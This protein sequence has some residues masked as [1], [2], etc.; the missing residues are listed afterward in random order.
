MPKVS[1]LQGNF[2]TG[3][4]SPL[5]YG[6]VDVDRYKSALTTCVNYIPMIQGGLLRRS[7]TA[8]VSEA[9]TSTK[10]TR[11]IPFEF[12][13]T[14]A[15]ILEFGDKYIRFYKDNGLITR[16]TQAIT[17][18]TQA[19]P[20][21]VTY[22]GSDTYANGDRV[23]INAV[24]GM[25]QLNNREFIVA[26]VNTGANTFQ[27]HDVLGNAVDGTAYDAYVSGGTIGEIYEVVSTYSEADLFDLKYT[28]SDD[29]LYLVHPSYPPKKLSRTGDTSWTLTTIDFLDGP[30][31]SP[32]STTTTLTPSAATGTVAIS[33]SST[34][35]INND[36]GFQAT[37]VGRLI[38]VQ[39]G[40]AWGN[41]TITDV[42]TDTSIS[43]DVNATL[44]NTSAKAIW[45]LGLWSDTSGYPSCVVFHE[46]RL[47]FGG[48]E[49]SPQ[50]L[51]A[52]NAG[53]YENF[54]PTALDGAVVDSNALSF[55]FNSNDVNAVRW[56]TSDEKGLLAGSVAG[57]WVVSP[58]TAGEALS[59]TNVSAK[60]AT[61]YGSAN[62]QPV[63]VGKATL[64][65]QRA[66]RKVR[67]MAYFF[68]VGGFRSSDLTVLS[69][70]ITGEGLVQV[71]RQRE[72]QS[73]VW[74]IR[75][76]GAL[77]SMIYDRDL[78]SLKVGWARHVVGGQSDAADSSAI[79]ESVAVIPSPD[80]THD[81]IWLVVKRRI[82]GR[83]VRFIE[84]L[85]KFFETIDEQQDAFF[86]DAG[87]TYDA[88]VTISNATKAN[89][90]VVTANTHGFS[91]GDKILIRDV[92]G[93][94]DLNGNTY[95]VA[96]AATNSF[97]LTSLTGVNI[98]G[99][100]FGT[101][102]SGGTVRKMVSTISGLNHLEGETISILADGAVLP[103]QTV[104]KGKVTLTNPS[105]TV[106][107]GYGYASK[108]QLPRLDAGAADGTAIG[109]TRRIHRVGFM[110][111]RSL[112][113]KFGMSF[114]DLDT[115]TFRTS[116]DPMTRAPALFSGIISEE[117]E[118]DYD[119]ENQVCWQQDQPLPSLILAV[120]PQLITQD[121]G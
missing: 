35:G 93:M 4:I 84:Y 51:D 88:P 118:A 46:D 60:R 21:V 41:V 65:I 103:D 75:E 71:A 92:M 6:R 50:R 2:N 91:N 48:S 117:I 69:E 20:V 55:A 119:F 7:G 85:T 31:E 22:S 17:A 61:S 57:E 108:A 26:N 11:L 5:F 23:S 25:T 28:Q 54:A 107:L 52:S 90:V 56:M 43:A 18:A 32:N 38:R 81:D 49:A 76:D 42:W 29:I 16:A 79:V 102:V 30:Y 120:A 89:P 44:T 68:D 63:Q 9:K 101:Y 96:A 95:L 116:A 19:N 77:L 114:D 37:D 72:P 33:A 97:S 47:T 59:P 1:P 99:T 73:I 98:D 13:I 113:L 34:T 121:R 64:F 67:E 83:T 3:E 40:S 111:H 112:G 27:L 105:A 87:L 104:S 100:S 8:F 24:L 66:G 115:V 36:T 106:Q 78:D 74:G 53:D 58:S 110:L 94:D 12:S 82:N 15:Y 109:K 10:K 80:A 39:Q 14:Q 86:V 45:R 62:I 70:H